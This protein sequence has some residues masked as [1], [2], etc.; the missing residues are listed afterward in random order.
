MCYLFRVENSTFFIRRLYID[1]AL[2]RR[3]ILFHHC[4]NCRLKHYENIDF[5]FQS[6]VPINIP[7]VTF[8]TRYKG[9]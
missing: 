9:L 3:I 5:E 7:V 6:I 8:V 2:K 1:P 4:A